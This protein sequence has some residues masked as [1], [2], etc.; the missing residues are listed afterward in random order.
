MGSSRCPISLPPANPMDLC[1]AVLPRLP[2]GLLGGSRGHPS[3]SQVRGVAWVMRALKS[4]PRP[5]VQPCLWRGHEADD[6]YTE[7][8]ELGQPGHPVGRDSKDAG[9]LSVWACTASLTAGSEA[10][11]F[12]PLGSCFPPSAHS[13]HWL[14]RVVAISEVMGQ[15]G[16]R[17]L[18]QH[19]EALI[20]SLWSGS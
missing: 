9:L 10:A 6:D 5:G 12:L 2:L 7:A 15:D 8:R 14:Q 13:S 17:G 1:L 20:V 3:G 19:R 18:P 16:D 11:S 4:P